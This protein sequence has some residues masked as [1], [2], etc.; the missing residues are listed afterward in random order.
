MNG[1]GLNHLHLLFC[2]SG[3]HNFVVIAPVIMKF[4][5]GMKLDVF[6]T[7]VTKN[8]WRHY[9]YVSMTL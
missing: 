6:Y 4:R 9:Y 2:K 3:Y 5:T 8:L 1:G 7:A